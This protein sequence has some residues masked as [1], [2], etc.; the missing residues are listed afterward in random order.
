MTVSRYRSLQ[1][2]FFCLLW[3]LD[4]KYKVLKPTEYMEDEYTSVSMR[5]VTDRETEHTN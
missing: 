5:G 1:V 2:T 3:S 4:C